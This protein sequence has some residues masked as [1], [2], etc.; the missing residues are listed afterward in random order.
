MLR[1]WFVG[2]LSFLGSYVVCHS[3]HILDTTEYGVVLE[4]GAW[5][6]NNTVPNTLDLISDE[7]L[8]AA[9]PSSTVLMGESKPDYRH[10]LFVRHMNYT[11]PE[12]FLSYV[13]NWAPLALVPASSRQPCLLLYTQV[14][15]QVV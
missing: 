13:W 8:L 7:K 15:R 2:V 5:T 4:T 3:Y 6:P 9:L 14:Q 12:P 1:G 10:G 11:L